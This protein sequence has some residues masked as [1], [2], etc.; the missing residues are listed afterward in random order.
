MPKQWWQSSNGRCLGR[1]NGHQ[2]PAYGRH[3]VCYAR[4]RACAHSFD[5]YSRLPNLLSEYLGFL[6]METYSTKRQIFSNYDGYLQSSHWLAFRK[7]ILKERHERCEKCGSRNRLQVHHNTYDN[8]GAE[9]PEDVEL[10]CQDCHEDRH[11]RKF[12]GGFRFRRTPLPPL[13]KAI[14]CPCGQ[15]ANR[16]H[17]LN[18]QYYCKTHIQL[19]KD[20]IDVAEYVKQQRLERKHAKSAG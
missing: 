9:L 6:F 14:K 18:G 11:K 4:G 3:S 15:L 13:A 1:R 17:L 16:N 10:L 19:A 5:P 20:G 7:R 2:I 12:G 8:L